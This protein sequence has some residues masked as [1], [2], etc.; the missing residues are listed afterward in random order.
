M[1]NWKSLL[2]CTALIIAPALH[3]NPLSEC[4]PDWQKKA[5]SLGLSKDIT[6]SVIPG[7]EH[8]P[9]VLELDRRQPAF[10]VSFSSYF[11][12]RVSEQRIE[13]GRALIEEHR[14][15]LDRLTQE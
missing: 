7:L 13:R 6:D 15:L 10:T 8:L 12:N 2:V 3:A 14:S 4:Y 11:N 1:Y 5:R 9:R